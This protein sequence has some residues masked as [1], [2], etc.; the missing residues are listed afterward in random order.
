MFGKG[1][2]VQQDEDMED[3]GGEYDEYEYE[4][5]EEE[6]E[7]MTTIDPDDRNCPVHE[8]ECKIT[9]DCIALR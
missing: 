3:T 7:E 1:K 2:K 6:E 8:F 4:D 9:E 5:E